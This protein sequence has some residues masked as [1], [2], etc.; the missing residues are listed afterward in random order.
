MKYTIVIPAYNEGKHL[1]SALETLLLTLPDRVESVLH[2]V[3]IVE[4]GSLDDT[5]DVARRLE[6]RF[7]HVRAIT[8]SRG[9]YG[10][11][12]KRGMLEAS[13]THLSIMECD[14]LVP[15]FIERSIDL[16]DERDAALVVASKRH[17]RSRDGRPMKRRVLTHMFNRLVNVLV[18]YP[19]SD[20]HGL[21]SLRTDVAVR[22]CNLASTTDEV[23]QTELVV[24]AW[25]LGETVY[26]VP[27][28]IVEKRPV[29]VSVARR[30]PK[31][32]GLIGQLR[33][34]QR[35][36]TGTVG[37]VIEI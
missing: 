10:E 32:M 6:G 28:D 17:P 12:I 35:R 30:L 27:I 36:F 1:E 15:S 8:L 7:S 3:L 33:V 37:R 20:T 5:L 25:R 19:G 31:V 24:I 4:N 11:A 23:F 16:F 22:L 9:S 14:F 34:S 26:E 21:K 2:E 18:G 29:T 13:G